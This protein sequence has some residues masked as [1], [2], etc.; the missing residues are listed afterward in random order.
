MPTRERLGLC[1]L[2]L[3]VAPC[4]V[5]WGVTQPF[6]G[7]QSNAAGGVDPR[8]LEAHVRMLSETCC[9]RDY[10]SVDN[11]NK[12]AGY[13]ATQLAATGASI[14]EQ[15]FMAEGRQ[16]KNIIA[17][18]GPKTGARIVLGAHYDTC[19][20]LPGADDNASG[21]AGL[22]ELAGLL[23]NKPVSAPVELVAYTLEEP[24]FFRSANMGS[25]V[26]ARSLSN[27]NVEVR[28][29]ISLEMIGYFSDA[30]GSQHLP[31]ALLKP[32]YPSVGNFIVVVGDLGTLGLTRKVKRSMK[33]ASSLPVYSLNGPR[34]VPGVDFSD[35]RSYWEQGYPALMVTDT[36][37]FRNLAYHTPEDT[38]DRLDYTKMAEVV[39]GLHAAV[40][41]LAK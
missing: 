20:P 39:I 19:D 2:L 23:A 12:A 3:L 1:I 26:H 37:F 41:D 40:R 33:R 4:G 34:F 22:I 32:F 31:S 36:A 15:P 6:T 28:A 25:A 11:L 14:A 21:V 24:P 17:R 30:P 9:P 13:I 38:A 5:W 18:L 35:H 10:R 16:Y 7:A 27:A 8:R 29:M